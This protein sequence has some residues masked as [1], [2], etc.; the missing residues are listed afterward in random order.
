MKRFPVFLAILAALLYCSAQPA[1]A[2]H[3]RGGGPPAGKGP[4]ASGAPGGVSDRGK[5]DSKTETPADTHTGG[6]K[7]PGELLTQNTRLANKLT[8]LLPPGTNLQNAAGGFKNLGQFVAAV[9]VSH[10]LKIPFADLRAKLT[11]ANAESLGKTIHDLKPDAD[12]KA[13]AR[14]AQREAKD[15][16]EETHS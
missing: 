4:G 5:A 9:H 16:L 6:S 12:A 1:F 7:S 3:G 2:Q 11:G 15:D 8:G 13:E 10:N 14:K